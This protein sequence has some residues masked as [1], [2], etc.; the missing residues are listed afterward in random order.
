MLL[1]MLMMLL[2]LL[3]VLVLVLVLMVKRGVQRHSRHARYKHRDSKLS[4]SVGKNSVHTE[5]P[6]TRLL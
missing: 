6:T 4:S 5:R 1:L 3:V 2:L